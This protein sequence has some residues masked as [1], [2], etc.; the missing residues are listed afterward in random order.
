MKNSAP[1]VGPHDHVR[2]EASAPLTVV[3][4]GDYECPYTRASAPVIDALAA[5]HAGQV[6]LV[7]RH[8][9]LRHLHANAQVLSEITEAAAL[10][11]RFWEVHD[12]VMR[13]RELTERAVLHDLKAAGVDVDALAAQLGAEAL[14]ERIEADVRGG[15]AAGVH[16]T[17]TFFFNGEIHDGK[18]DEAT[19]RRLLDAALAP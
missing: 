12:R 13:H 4:Y 15:K 9:P 1:A 3:W 18:G 17:P 14:R 11:G 10:Q 8:F 7:F 5:E 16:S 2:G 6:R 19:L